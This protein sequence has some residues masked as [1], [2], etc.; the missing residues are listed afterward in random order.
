MENSPPFNPALDWT[1]NN[2]YL[3]R[4][5]SHFFE[6]LNLSL[7]EAER[8]FQQLLNLIRNYERTTRKQ[9]SQERKRRIDPG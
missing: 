7:S 1:V 4:A 8:Y 3:N 2:R 6:H 9:V 5:N